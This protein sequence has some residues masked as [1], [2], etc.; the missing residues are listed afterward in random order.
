MPQ[1]N[2]YHYVASSAVSEKMILLFFNGFWTI[3]REKISIPHYRPD[4]WIKHS[5]ITKALVV[6]E[7]TELLSSKIFFVVDIWTLRKKWNLFVGKEHM[8]IS[9]ARNFCESNNGRLPCPERTEPSKKYRPLIVKAWCN[10][11]HRSIN[12]LRSRKA[13]RFQNLL[14]FARSHSI[15]TQG[16]VSRSCATTPQSSCFT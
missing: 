15:V 8:T 11:L 2:W 14:C 3:I 6:C 9:E 12:W 5:N 1:V 7:R 10:I 16:P 4:G 13:V